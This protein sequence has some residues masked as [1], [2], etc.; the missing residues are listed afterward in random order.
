M[1]LLVNFNH[2]KKVVGRMSTKER[3]PDEIAWLAG[4][5]PQVVGCRPLLYNSYFR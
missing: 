1:G 5:G 2:E 3:W 4:S